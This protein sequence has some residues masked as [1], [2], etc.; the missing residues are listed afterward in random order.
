MS[1]TH[2]SRCQ[3]LVACVACGKCPSYVGVRDGRLLVLCGE[4][5]L[6]FLT[7]EERGSNVVRPEARR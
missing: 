4:H 7:I 1:R 6:L 5:A 3:H 2:A